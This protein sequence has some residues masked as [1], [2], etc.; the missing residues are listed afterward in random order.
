MQKFKLIFDHGQQTCQNTILDKIQ[1][2][3]LRWK[4]DSYVR[5]LQTCKTWRGQIQKFEWH[6]KFG[7]FIAMKLQVNPIEKHVNSIFTEMIY[8]R[9]ILNKAISVNDGQLHKPS[10]GHVKPPGCQAIKA[11]F[12]SRRNQQ[13][14]MTYLLEQADNKAYQKLLWNLKNYKRAIP[15]KL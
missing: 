6:W 8:F 14:V 9:L 7:P 2:I 15:D 3:E 1:K 12:F 11:I 13:N 10:L 5:P 4:F